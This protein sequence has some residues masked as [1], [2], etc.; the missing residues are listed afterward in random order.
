ME[1]FSTVNVPKAV[2]HEMDM[3]ESL[4]KSISL[5]VGCF[6]TGKYVQADEE[7]EE[8]I[9]KELRMQTEEKQA[10]DIAEF[11]N[12]MMINE[13]NECRKYIAEMEDDMILDSVVMEV[14]E[15]I[16]RQ[17]ERLVFLFEVEAENERQKAENGDIFDV[18]EEDENE[19]RNEEKER[20]QKQLMDYETELYE[21]LWNMKN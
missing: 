19:M 17:K 5:R 13:E 18:T 9:D 1:N 2:E 21:V 20:K 16:A 8:E 4:V 6:M 15:E 3:I 14:E 11:E 12:D 10:N 7:D